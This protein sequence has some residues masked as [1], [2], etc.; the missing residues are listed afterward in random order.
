[1]DHA[2]VHGDWI[3]TVAVSAESREAGEDSGV[4]RRSKGWTEGESF[5]FERFGFENYYRSMNDTSIR[6]TPRLPESWHVFIQETAL[7]S[8]KRCI[9]VFD[10]LSP[11]TTENKKEKKKI[12]SSLPALYGRFTLQNQ[13]KNDKNHDYTS[14]RTTDS[15]NTIR[16]RPGKD[17]V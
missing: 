11:W 17:P 1:M 4:A 10:S 15:V 2:A 8:P 12:Q 13:Y 7:L 6:V 14:R 3:K 16:I 5:G 9:Q